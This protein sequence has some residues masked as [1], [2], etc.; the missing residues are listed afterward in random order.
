MIKLSSRRRGGRSKNSTQFLCVPVLQKFG[1]PDLGGGHSHNSCGFLNQSMSSYESL[2][3]LL[4]QLP[5]SE[6]QQNEA[7]GCT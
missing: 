3:R 2:K 1:L 4:R 7:V 6:E 5:L